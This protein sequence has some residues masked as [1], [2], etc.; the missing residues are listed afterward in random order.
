M[1]N[2]SNRGTFK[3]VLFEEEDNRCKPNNIFDDDLITETEK[4]VPGSSSE[5][6]SLICLI[7]DD[8]DIEEIVYFANV[9]I[10]F[11]FSLLFIEYHIIFRIKKLIPTSGR[12]SP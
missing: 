12:R 11:K 2:T 5:L 10:I 7:D 3:D 4:N 6:P 8:S 9:I 1:N